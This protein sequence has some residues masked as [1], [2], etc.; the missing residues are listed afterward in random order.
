MF[1]LRDD[2]PRYSQSYITV[3]LIILNVVVF[4]FETSLD[5]YSRNH[6]IAA[7]ALI[8]GHFRP[9][10]LLSAMFLHGGWMHIISN[11]VFLW[12]FGR[13]LEDAMG[14]G[15]FLLFYLLC[16]IV[17]GMTQVFLSGGSRVPT[18]GASG[19]IA[20]VMGAYLLLF[21]RAHIR[22]L[23]VLFIFITTA[24]IPAMILLGY[25][26]I[27]Q[28]FNGV[29]AIGY[30]HVSEGGVAWFEHIGGF[31]AGMILVKTLG[32]QARMYRRPQVYW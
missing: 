6:F 9:F 3:L 23:I 20:G 30:S 28:L 16:G 27:T 25:W 17:A 22:T 29:G 26:F 11:M 5:D 1:P 14:H 2:Q 18:V 32:T 31:I 12:A 24:D 4:L 8:P 7:Y 10:M 13:S 19:A 15:K 21:P